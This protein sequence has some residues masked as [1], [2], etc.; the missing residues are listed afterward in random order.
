MAGNSPAR[1]PW[2]VRLV[3]VIAGGL[4]VWLVI[5]MIFNSV[6]SLGWALRLTQWV[7]VPSLLIVIV[8]PWTFSSRKGV[9]I[10]L[11]LG[12]VIGWFVILMIFNS[13]FSLGWALR[14]TQWIIVPSLFI[15]WAYRKFIQAPPAP[16]QAQRVYANV[17]DVPR[18]EPE[19]D[20]DPSPFDDDESEIDIPPFLRGQRRRR[21]GTPDAPPAGSSRRG[22]ES[23]SDIPPSQRR[24][25]FGD[26]ADEPPA[27]PSADL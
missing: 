17:Q 2:W 7:I 21:S 27:D 1:L 4:I 20:L 16:R 15:F 5:L 22:Y 8:K 9:L 10:G 24:R 26:E 12:S 23:V 6:F 14:L 19:R 25:F 18:V 3:N 13:V 11:G